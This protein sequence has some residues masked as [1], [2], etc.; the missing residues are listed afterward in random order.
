MKRL[1][2]IDKDKYPCFNKSLKNLKGEQWREIPHTEGYYLISNYGRVR[3]LA[4][5]TESGDF[6]SV[7]RIKEKILSQCISKNRN[8]YK[9]DYTFGMVVRLQFNK[10]KFAY[11]VRRLVYEAFVQPF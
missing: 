7:I 10:R 3:A 9:C 11:M 1:Y 4:R 2:D 6:G 5:Y 8:H